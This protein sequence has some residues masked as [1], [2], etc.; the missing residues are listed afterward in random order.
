MNSR[1]RI[2]AAITCQTVDRTPWVPFVGA[3]AANLLNLTATEYLRSAEHMVQG[4]NTAIERYQPDGI[5]IAFDLQIEAEALGCELQWADDNPPAV[6]S[7]PLA[8]GTTLSDLTV[9]GPQDGRIGTVMQVALALRQQHPDL[10]LYGL[11]TGPFTLALHLRGTNIFMD[12]FDKPD[13]VHALLAFC[14]QV[15]LAMSQYYLD[16]DTDV[17]ALVDPMTSQIGPDQF[18]EFVQP[19]VTEVFDFIRE[20]KGLSS[21]FVCGHAQ[22]NIPVMC[23]CHCDNISIDENIPLDYVR[24]ECRQRQISFGGN[25]QLTRILLLGQ[26][27]D[28]QRNALSCMDAAGDTGFILAPGCDVPYATPPE[29]LIAVTELVRDPYNRQ[30]IEA[31][32]QQAEETEGIDLKDYG[33]AD[34][35]IIDIITLDSEACAPCQYMVDAVKKVT[36]EFQGIVEWREH[37]IKSPEAL[38]FMN[39]LMVN[40][41]PTICIDG[42]ITFVSRIPP[43]DRLIA[44]I[45]QRINEKSRLRIQQKQTQIHVLGPDNEETQSALNNVRQAIAELGRDV[46][47]EHCHDAEAMAQYG[48]MPSQTPAI[49]VTH[50]QLKSIRRIPE[51]VVIKEWLKAL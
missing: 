48:I 27:I 14:T 1:Q 9:P 26:P 49:V 21:F 20:R 28:A 37:K 11:I 8:N 12:M 13:D 39:G 7:H 46:E 6:I 51:V 42:Q 17:I 15:G 50:S 33:Q 47:V 43:R 25:L 24:D 34:K 3:H 31:M 45:Q 44:A 32:T 36:P 41:I 5:P 16:A 30:V 38:V 18:V 10:A 22:Q 2:Q 23:D 4:V 40:N 19:Y 29:N 35:V